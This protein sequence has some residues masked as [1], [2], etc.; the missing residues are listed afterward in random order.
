MIHR[1]LKSLNLNLSINDEYRLFTDFS[2]LINTA[3]IN[4]HNGHQDL[5]DINSQ[6]VNHNNFSKIYIVINQ[7]NLSDIQKR[8]GTLDMKYKIL[9]NNFY[10]L[11]IENFLRN[12]VYKN[13]MHFGI[14]YNPFVA[15]KYLLL[16][17]IAQ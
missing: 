10:D 17:L 13:L 6:V 7:N 3:K 8:L 9:T 15:E 16:E 1:D 12:S 14:V 11:S 4:L 5:Q 2:K